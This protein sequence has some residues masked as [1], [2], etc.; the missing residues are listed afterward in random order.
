MTSHR[1]LS[2][3]LVAIRAYLLAARLEYVWMFLS[4][5]SAARQLFTAF[6][7]RNCRDYLH[8]SL[9][10]AFLQSALTSRY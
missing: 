3:V 2:T 4:A 7:G 6:C 1:K 8:G 5:V 9:V 10:S